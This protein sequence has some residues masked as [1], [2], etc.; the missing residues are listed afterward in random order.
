M[1]QYKKDFINSRNSFIRDYK[2]KTLQ[3]KFNTAKKAERP[4]TREK[5]KRKSYSS[6]R[7][8]TYSRRSRNHSSRHSISEVKEK[9]SFTELNL[10]LDKMVVN[11]SCSKYPVIAQIASEEFGMVISHDYSAEGNWDIFWSDAVSRYL[12]FLI[13]LLP[14]R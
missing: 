5:L 9:L 4:I 10:H 12:N 8:S 11:L 2:E 13:Q 14:F 6:L 1:R 7:K 3:I